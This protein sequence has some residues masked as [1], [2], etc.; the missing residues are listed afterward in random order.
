VARGTKVDAP[1]ALRIAIAVT[2]GIGTAAPVHRDRR[3]RE[4]A[5]DHVQSIVAVDHPR[6]ATTIAVLPSRR[7][8]RFSPSR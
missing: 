3:K 6:D 4:T 5:V 2:T 8:R 1:N 7:R